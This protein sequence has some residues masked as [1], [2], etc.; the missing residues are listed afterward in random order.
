M[1]IEVGRVLARLAESGGRGNVALDDGL[2]REVL[3]ALAIVDIEEIGRPAS[4]GE[5]DGCGK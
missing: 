2:A 3:G 1:G 4:S 5:V